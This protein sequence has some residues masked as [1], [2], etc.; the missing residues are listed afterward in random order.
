MI[1]Q[2]KRINQKHNSN[3][4]KLD[5]NDKFIEY[6]QVLDLKNYVVGPDKDK[7]VYHLYGVVLL[8]KSINSCNYISYCKNLGIWLDYEDDSIYR[9]EDPINKDAYILFYK[10]RSYD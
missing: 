7:S 3:S 1:I 10:R 2:L 5:I 8:K 6:N 4:K 9:I